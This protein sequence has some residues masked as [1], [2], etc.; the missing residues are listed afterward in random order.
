MQ[1]TIKFTDFENKYSTRLIVSDT[2]K[3]C[4]M[5]KSAVL[6]P[7]AARPVVLNLGVLGPQGVYGRNFL[8]STDQQIRQAQL[9]DNH[10][11]NLLCSICCVLFNEVFAA[12]RLEKGPSHSQFSVTVSLSSISQVFHLQLLDADQTCFSVHLSCCFQLANSKPSYF[13]F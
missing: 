8:G 6:C 1:Y 10:R 4:F 2:L 9:K 3:R 5:A 12:I 11:I 13:P 7:P